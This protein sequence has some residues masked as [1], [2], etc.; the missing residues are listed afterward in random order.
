MKALD[1]Q[2]ANDKS[3]F[4]KRKSALEAQQQK[5]QEQG[6]SATVERLNEQIPK[7]QQEFDGRMQRLEERRQKLQEQIDQPSQKDPNKPAKS[8]QTAK[9]SNEPNT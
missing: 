7:E 8:K 4:N 6:D 5:A 9:N 1:E 3:N 2:M